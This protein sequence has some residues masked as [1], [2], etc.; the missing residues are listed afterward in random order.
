MQSRIRLLGLERLGGLRSMLQGCRSRRARGPVRPR[1]CVKYFLSL[2]QKTCYQRKLRQ[3][4]CILFNFI[5]QKKPFGTWQFGTIRVF[6]NSITKK[7]KSKHLV[8][9]S[10]LWWQF[11]FWGNKRKYFIHIP[12]LNPISTGGKI[13]P[14]TLLLASP[15]QTFR[16]SY[17][18]GSQCI[19]L[20]SDYNL[21]LLYYVS[22]VK[23][24]TFPCALGPFRLW[25]FGLSCN[26][27]DSW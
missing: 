5:H 22:Y 2:P 27:M 16:P 20:P 12:G 24:D 25:S 6:V 3:T 8:C 19:F 7:L 14:A 23:Q 9:L 11:F 17:G 1:I 15:S 10:F 26:K 4:K 18:P 21:L 13:M